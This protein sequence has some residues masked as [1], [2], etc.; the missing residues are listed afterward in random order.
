MT[1]LHPLTV[2]AMGNRLCGDD[3]IGP[4]IL[5][6]LSAM[7]DTR[8]ELMAGGMDALAMLD[9]IQDRD[10]VL[11]LDAARMGLRAGTIRSFGKREV[12]F[13]LKED[14][15]SLHGIGL[16]DALRLGEELKLL[17]PELNFIGIEPESVTINTPL[18]PVVRAQ[19]PT[20]IQMI[21]EEIEPLPYLH[22]PGKVAERVSEGT[23]HV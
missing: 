16:A 20:V 3:G 5:D 23:S 17:P 19:I 1:C 9:R 12:E 22:Q 4:V 6:A 8:L 10:R 14:H 21:L 11:I 7:A 2:V 15:L 13:I 18:S